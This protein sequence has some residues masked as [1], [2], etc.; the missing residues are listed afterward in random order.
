MKISVYLK[1]NTF[2]YP[3]GFVDKNNPKYT[4]LQFF[5]FLLVI[6]QTRK[7]Q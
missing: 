2:K 4:Y 3:T 6:V 5:N 7:R 1:N